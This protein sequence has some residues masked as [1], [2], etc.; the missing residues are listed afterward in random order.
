MEMNIDHQ[1]SIA[2]SASPPSPFTQTHPHLLQRPDKLNSP[3]LDAFAGRIPTPIHSNFNLAQQHGP[4]SLGPSRSRTDSVLPAAAA[5]MN[6]VPRFAAPMKHILETDYAMPSPIAESPLIE[7]EDDDLHMEMS[8]FPSS[9]LSRLSVSQ[10]GMMDVDERTMW[11]QHSGMMQRSSSNMSGDGGGGGLMFD[12]TP[13]TPTTPGR[14]GRAR[15]G[16]FS[17]SDGGGADKGGRR[18]VFGYREDCEK[19]RMRVPGHFA[20][21][22]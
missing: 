7:D 8:D 1:I 19:C 5:N 11:S 15:S 18:V 2:G 12:V 3:G 21:F 14:T 6:V 13:P 22:V 9:Q 10:D 16:A 4:S 17:A 20:H